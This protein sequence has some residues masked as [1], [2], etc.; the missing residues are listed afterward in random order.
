MLRMFQTG[1]HVGASDWALGARAEVVRSGEV[2][3]KGDVLYG[4][5]AQ[6]MHAT[7]ANARVHFKLD[8]CVPPPDPDQMNSEAWVVRLRGDPNVAIRDLDRSSYWD[9][10]AAHRI[11]DVVFM[12]AREEQLAGLR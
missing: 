11:T 12:T 2:V 8:W 1:Y 10:V 3:A 4:M 6:G 9:G 7:Y 5:P